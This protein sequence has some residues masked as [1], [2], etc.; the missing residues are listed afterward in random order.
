MF[1]GI[2]YKTTNLI[3]GKIYIGQTT[4]F[5]STYLGSGNLIQKAI[6]KYNKHNFKRETLEVCYNQEQLNS[7]EEYYIELYSSTNPNVGYNL[8]KVALGLH[9][10]FH[11]SEETKE[12]MRKF[13]KEKPLSNKHILNLIISKNKVE[14][15]Q[16]AKES[17]IGKC[18]KSI[19]QLNPIT[20]EIIA[21]FPS[22]KEASIFFKGISDCLAGITKFAG[23]F[24]WKYKN[25]PTPEYKKNFYIPKRVYQI[26]PISNQI[27]KIWNSP[28]QIE[29]E[30]GWVP[31]FKSKCGISH[32]FK[33]YY[34]E[35]FNKQL[36][37]A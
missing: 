4:N 35:D 2:I 20:E 7:N 27:V 33:W 28:R 36:K 11:H 3:N 19:Y 23:G 25:Q 24:K 26:D 17:H 31:D 30:L 5:N 22:I 10:G 8:S 34:E 16:K 12:K 9:K 29:K 37:V 18:N 13:A 6:K 14:S 15:I 1:K 21:E 32:K